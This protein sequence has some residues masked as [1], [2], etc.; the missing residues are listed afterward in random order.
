LSKSLFQ[1]RLTLRT[2]INSKIGLKADFAVEKIIE[3]ENLFLQRGVDGGLENA[4]GLGTDDEGIAVRKI[5][6]I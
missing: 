6:C 3:S 2:K 4:V 1:L 5:D